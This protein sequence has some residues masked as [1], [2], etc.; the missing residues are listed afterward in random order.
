IDVS[1]HADQRLTRARVARV[2]SR[3][4][5][6]LVTRYRPVRERSI[7]GVLMP[8]S[9]NLLAALNQYPTTMSLLRWR[10]SESQ[11]PVAYLR[12]ERGKPVKDEGHLM[13]VVTFLLNGSPPAPGAAARL[14][15]I[16][17]GGRLHGLLTT[18][19]SDF[20][21]NLRPGARQDNKAMNYFDGTKNRLTTDV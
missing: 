12:G 11:A 19:W 21:R 6:P 20:K 8:F 16:K 17:Q 10:S 2:P 18:A 14:Q 5:A 9:D 1:P 7:R 15:R 4:S 13:A 3:F